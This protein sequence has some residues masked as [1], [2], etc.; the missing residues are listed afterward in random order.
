MKKS[1]FNFNWPLVGNQHITEF[2]ERIIIKDEVSGTYIF[3]GPDNLGKTTA[4]IHFAKSLLC[5]NHEAGG[6]LPC[7]E[8]PSCRRFV[9]SADELTPDSQMEIG[10]THGDYH[11]IK[12]AKDKKNIAIEQVREFIRTLSLSSFLNSYKIGIIKH[13]EY[14]SI[15][16]A[17]A[18]LKTLEEPREKVVLVLITNDTELL[19]STIVSRS[20]ILN[21]RPVKADLIYDYLVKEKKASRS[22]AKN[23]SRLCLGRPA[24]AVKFL[25]NKSFCENYLAKARTFLDY[26]QTDL[27]QK[28]FTIEE[29]LGKK[30][31]GQEAVKT[32]QRTI[33]IWQGII[34]DLILLEFG[35]QEFIG[36]Q[37]L[38]E[39]MINIKNKFS[40]NELFS[41]IKI[42]RQAEENLLA[43]VNPKL[44]LENA[45]IYL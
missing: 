1:N 44:V 41:F 26:R 42:L 18:L 4:A 9:A 35:R 8:C 14:L 13:A 21:F 33:E 34:R 12:K 10:E 25:E 38:A 17:N 23:F 29:L 20:K 24:L 31:S 32:A 2:L 11:V 15:E 5:Q 45:V 30:A 28:F 16:A 22:E 27:N 7:L 43:N 37:V 39:E 3:N 40:L 36:F 6:T 19:P